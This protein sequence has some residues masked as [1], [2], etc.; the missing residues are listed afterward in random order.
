MKYIT[1]EGTEVKL[2]TIEECAQ[3]VRCGALA[4]DSLVQEGI[5]GRWIAASMHP[6]SAVL[7]KPASAAGAKKVAPSRLRAWAYICWIIAL[8]AP[9]IIA[10]VSGRNVAFVLGEA[11]GA[12]LLFGLIG[13]VAMLFVKGTVGR[14]R[15]SIGIALAVAAVE[16]PQQIQQVQVAAQQKQ[17][18]QASAT[19]LQAAADSLNTPPSTVVAS[20]TGVGHAPPP[21]SLSTSTQLKPVLSD[22]AAAAVLMDTMAEFIRA[23]NRLADNYSKL[24]ASYNVDQMLTPAFLLS[25]QQLREG[26]AVLDKWDRSLTAFEQA[27][28]RLTTEFQEKVQSLNMNE[29]DKQNFLTR[30]GSGRLKAERARTEFMQT[31][32]A[33]LR[34]MRDMYAFM[35]DRL[36]IVQLRGGKLLFATS[37]DLDTYNASIERI[38]ALA[39][40]EDRELQEEQVRRVEASKVLRAA[41]QEVLRH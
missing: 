24:I 41:T 27:S 23:T 37:A 14:L 11:L 9:P 32:R 7:F 16:I 6:D 39:A 10:V 38:K 18:L 34:E 4:A 33:V 21:E 31:E 3:A 36:G 13:L 40:R 2:E 12:T 35:A 29:A 5:N 1:R 15:L 8:T 25:A 17:R 26:R 20:P 22:A 28:I 30:F 19:R